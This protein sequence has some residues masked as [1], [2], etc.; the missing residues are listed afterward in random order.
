M[1]NDGEKAPAGRGSSGRTNL[2]FDFMNGLK[3][4]KRRVRDF[5]QG[6]ESGV[7]TW[8]SVGNQVGMYRPASSLWWKHPDL[9]IGSI[10][11]TPSA[12]T[13]LALLMCPDLGEAESYIWAD[14][15][16]V[17]ERATQVVS[18]AFSRNLCTKEAS[19]LLPVYARIFDMFQGRDDM[20]V[21][22]IG[23]GSN[24]P[25]MVSNMQG[26]APV[27]SSLR[28]YRDMWPHADVMGADFD[29]RALFTEEGIATAWVDQTDVTALATLPEKFGCDQFDLVIDDG[30][31]SAEA[32]LNTLIFALSH[33][34]ENGVIWIEDIAV[35]ALP[36]WEL[37]V[38]LLAT[39]GVR[40]TLIRPNQDGLGLLVET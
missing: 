34:R 4:T 14:A 19:G 36:I 26:A 17:T 15:L 12:L 20:R 25:D 38:V 21:L 32:N 23:I 27:G 7:A 3:S 40:S 39:G 10:L 6:A 31:H 2:R 18:G 22:E 8:S 24:S 28:S 9:L 1:G 30:L 13:E 35:D 16:A 37:V 33:V 11:R 5:R 29:R